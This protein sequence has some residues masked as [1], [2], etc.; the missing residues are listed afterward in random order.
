MCQLERS[1]RDQFVDPLTKHLNGRQYQASSIQLSQPR[2]KSVLSPF[3]ALFLKFPMIV[4]VA[5]GLVSCGEG[6]GTIE[7]LNAR[8]LVNDFAKSEIVSNGPGIADGKTE[9][10]MVV[11]LVNG[12]DT[13]VVG[14]RPTYEVASGAG[15]IPS[16][17]TRSDNVGAAI[18]VVRA[19]IPGTKRL[20]VNNVKI[21]LK[22]DVDFLAPPDKGNTSGLVVGALPN[23]TGTSG[24]V[25]Q[26]SIESSPAGQPKISTSG[27]KMSG[28]VQGSV[29]LQ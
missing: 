24:Y 26:G 13:S 28:S 19:T 25:L 22:K 29:L 8:A 7:E 15:V 3:L 23:N 11:R 9:L 4:L 27:W 16:E 21:E 12:N 5:L 2:F 10:I 18:C 1:P 14:Y 20:S 6:K 17:C